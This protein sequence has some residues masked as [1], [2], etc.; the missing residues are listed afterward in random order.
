MQRSKFNQ[1]CFKIWGELSACREY[2]TG[3]V[4]SAEMMQDLIED[5]EDTKQDVQELLNVV[6]LEG[7]NG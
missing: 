5:L 2:W 4:F 6:K 7:I 3:A 1:E